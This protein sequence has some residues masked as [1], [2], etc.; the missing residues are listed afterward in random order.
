MAI[1]NSY[2]KLPEG[3]LQWFF[4]GDLPLQWWPNMMI[5][6]D[7]D[8]QSYSDFWLLWDDELHLGWLGCPPVVFVAIS[9]G[10]RISAISAIRSIKIISQFGYPLVITN[11]D[12]ACPCLSNTTSRGYLDV[13][14]RNR[15][16]FPN[17]LATQ[18]IAYWIRFVLSY[19]YI[20]LIYVCIYIWYN[21][22]IYTY[23]YI[24]IY[25]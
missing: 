14:P 8:R 19:I 2:V 25:I 21:I 17:Y 23:I 1:F 9:N 10:G 24:H 3:I 11:S 5:W 7:S 18:D 13:H 4:F 22:Y 16:S 6:M 15:N 20:W 12:H